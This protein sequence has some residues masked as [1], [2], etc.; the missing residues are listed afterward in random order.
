MLEKVT[1]QKKTHDIERR[2]TPHSSV[3]NPHV[4]LVQTEKLLEEK[5]I[6]EART[7]ENIARRESL[8]ASIVANNLLERFEEDLEETDLS[9]SVI[10]RIV[11]AAIGFQMHE[12]VQALAYPHDLR[13]RFISVIVTR[14]E[15]G[16][17][18]PE[19]VI[20][21]LHERAQSYG[22][23]AG[24][25]M[26]KVDIK[27]SPKGWAVL[28]TEQDHRDNDLPMAYY[29]R[30]FRWLYRRGIQNYL[31]VVRAE[32]EHRVG[33]DGKWYRA[34]SLSIVTR[35]P[36]EVIRLEMARLDAQVGKG[37]YVSELKNEMAT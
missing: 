37:E 22:F 23:D 35:L 33:D 2:H 21:F 11:D 7:M 27:S 28:G 26:S 4:H 5:V 29:A 9:E 36:V 15:K 20:A 31:Y 16:E 1:K 13:E 18:Q 3:P 34:P 12:I 14:I 8:F 30:C 19:D 25:H 6:R 24:F 10:A 17:L 32:R